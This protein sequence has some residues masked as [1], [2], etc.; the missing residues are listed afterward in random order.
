[1]SRRTPRFRTPIAAVALGLAALLAASAAPAT[2]PPQQE[3]EAQAIPTPSAEAPPPPGT[4]GAESPP[5]GRYVGVATCASATCH[6]ATRPQDAYPVLQNEYYTWLQVDRHAKAYEVLFDERSRAIAR[7][8]GLG[9]AHRERRCLD[10]HALA[11]PAGVVAGRLE[12]DD[13]VTC[14]S[15]HGPAS[16]WLEGHRSADWSH[17]DSVAA[18]M[19]D[20]RP[21]GARA[22]LCL[23]C[24]LGAPGRQVD[25]ELIAAGHP[26]LV[27]ELDNYT[28]AMPPHWNP[29]Q[30]PSARRDDPERARQ[31][32][33]SQGA[34]A[35]AVGQSRA[36]AAGFEQLARRARSGPWPEFAEMRCDDCH[37]SLAQERWRWPL[38]PGRRAGT[39]A[40]NRARWEVLR[41]L[42]AEA[43]PGRL[44]ELERKVEA[45]AAAVPD[46]SVS[47][48]EVARRA[49]EAAAALAEIE[50]RLGAL[51]WDAGRLSSLL[52]SLAAAGAPTDYDG[53][54]QVLF[55][56]NAL[57]A[58]LIG[59]RPAVAGS[60]L[61]ATLDAM[62]GALASRAGYDRE[63]F[64]ALLG[65]LDDEVRGLPR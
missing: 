3:S 10:C 15:C 7:N 62:D 17:A 39:P 33:A 20:L 14:E 54:A 48:A 63:R 25:H 57:A 2:P 8:L 44:D 6:G 42:V 21:A 65:R 16:G 56:A 43:A 1:M 29:P 37:H 24:H 36:L 23:D 60:G 27:F 31:M 53:A 55:A 64:G 41:S 9:A 46:F 12:I 22:R 35:W 50:P 47:G 58:E 32:A 51:S 59:R 19:R 18:G 34:R 30:L 13:G 26:A 49:D 61:P 38:E 28:G 4:P 40:W 45:V 52:G 11:P 5:P